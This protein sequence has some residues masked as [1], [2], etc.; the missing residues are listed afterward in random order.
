MT[1]VPRY[2]SLRLRL[3]DG[4]RNRAFSLKAMSFAL[5][6]VINTLVDYSVFL[7]ARA[8]L[9]RSTTALSLFD[10][11][12]ASCRCGNATTL[13]LIAANMMSWIVAIAGSYIMNSSITFAAETGRKLRWRAY[14]AF[15][16][17]GVAGLIANTATL[18]FAAE[19]LL[20]PVWLAKAVAILA[21]FLVNFSLSH[22]VVFRARSRPAGT[23]KYDV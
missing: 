8:A 19:I 14:L 17:A 9:G 12:A 7:V 23:A 1:R 20:A 2:D 21:S 5:I 10:S 11:L 6:G 4:W 16:A 13:S 3:L 18:V 22:F 15:V